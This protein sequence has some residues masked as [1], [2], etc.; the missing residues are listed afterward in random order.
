MWIGHIIK[1]YLSWTSLTILRP[2]FVDRRR[3]RAGWVDASLLGF[4]P[5]DETHDGVLAECEIIYVG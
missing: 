1:M 5:I 2:L 3:I 4:A